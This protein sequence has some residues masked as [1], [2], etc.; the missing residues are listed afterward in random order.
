MKK[1]IFFILI[2]VLLLSLIGCSGQTVTVVQPIITTT[3]KSIPLSNT[4]ATI[5]K[6]STSHKTDYTTN[7]H[8][9]YFLDISLIPS[10]SAIADKSYSVDLYEKG[11]VRDSENINW[12]QPEINVNK[13]KTIEYALSKTEYDAYSGADVSGIFT[14]KLIESPITTS[15]TRSITVKPLITTTPMQ[16]IIVTHDNTPNFNITSPKDG[17]VWHVGDTVAIKWTS[18]NV[19]AN[20]TL[21]V[22]IVDGYGSHVVIG[23]TKNTG[24][25]NWI[26]TSNTLGT[27]MIPSLDMQGGGYGGNVVFIS[28]LAK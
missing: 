12:N 21:S 17:D 16:T 9:F 8:D 3:Q 14:V 6:I 15:S 7:I 24:N 20:T 19:P 23:T 13:S 4:T 11:I 28:I 25:F 27:K 26:V 18:S 1:L 22:S 2:T 5:G 10:S